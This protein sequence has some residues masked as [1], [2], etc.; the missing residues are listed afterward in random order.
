MVF[1]KYAHVFCSGVGRSGGFS[2]LASWEDPG[3]A[4]AATE[5]EVEAI[6]EDGVDDGSDGEAL[7]KDVLRRRWSR[8]A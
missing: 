5:E 4:V 6:A 1:L 8:P 7:D 2:L 3:A